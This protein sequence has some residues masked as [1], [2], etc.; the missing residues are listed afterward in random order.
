MLVRVDDADRH[1][2]R[3]AEAG[4]RILD[5]PTDY[6]YGERQYNAEDLGGHRWTF[7]Q[8]TADVDPE[9]WGGRPIKLD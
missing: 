2:D 6:P 9:T 1:R 8:S 7:S 4:A 3:A 5:E